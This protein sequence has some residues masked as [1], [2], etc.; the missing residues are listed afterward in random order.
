MWRDA[1]W[2]GAGV[3]VPIHLYSLGSDLKPDWPDKYAAQPD[4]LAYWESLI[5]R[6]GG[7]LLGGAVD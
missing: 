7:S 6:H 2:A 1:K 5:D 3:D 4:V